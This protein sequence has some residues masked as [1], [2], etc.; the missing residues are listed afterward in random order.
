MSTISIDV[1]DLSAERKRELLATMLEPGRKKPRPFPLSFAQ[2]R[3]W[4]VDQLAPESAS[5]N[6]PGVL[7]LLGQL[8]IDVLDRTFTE[9][10][11]RHASLRTIFTVV[12]DQPMQL[13][14]P[15]EL[16][17]LPLAD[18]SELSILDR[19]TEIEERAHAEARR[20]FDLRQGPLWRGQLL[21]VSS[22]EHVLLFTLHHIIGDGWSLG[23]LFK[24]LC[25]IYEAFS[26]GLP[27]PLAE[28][29]I[30]YVD[31]ALW[32][33]EWL[34]GEVLR[35]HLNYWRE[36]LKGAP[37]VIELPTDRARPAIQQYVGARLPLSFPKN[38][39]MGLKALHRQDGITLFM[40]LLAGWQTLLW[41]YTG[42]SDVVIGAPI[43]NRQ[44]TELEPLIGF[45]VNTLVLRTNLSGEP[46]VRELL[47]RVREAC[48]G[49]YAHQDMPFEALVDEL[50]PE[51]ALSH[52]PLFQVMMVLQD[53]I[54]RS[55]EAAELKLILL[56]IDNSTAKF[57]LML[58]LEING[59]EL[60][61]YLEFNTDLFEVDTI[62]RM[63]G[64]YQTLLAGMLADQDQKI[65][66]LPLMT[67]AEQ[68]QL[69]VQW[70]QTAFTFSPDQPVHALFDLQAERTPDAIAVVGFETKISY[71]SL[72][73]RAN[74]LAQHLQKLG[75]GAEAC[76]AV[77]LERS[78]EWVICLLAILKAGA[79]Y[80]P[81]DASS[82]PERI[83]FML[84]D[85]Q[86][87]IVLTSTLLA[88]N[89]DG[90]GS[91]LICLDCEWDDLAA[92]STE[93]PANRA[94]PDNLA[95][96]IYTSGST[97][98]PKG[99]AVAHRELQ[100]LVQWHSGAFALKPGDRSTQLA[101]L[102]FDATVWELWPY[103]TSGACIYLATEEVRVSPEALRDWL[104]AEEITVSWVPTPLAE[105]LLA[106]EWP[107]NTALR[108]LNI[109]GEQL[110]RYPSASLPFAVVN[111]Y[112]PT[113]AT[114][115]VSS[116][117][118]EPTELPTHLP[119]I[120]RPIANVKFFV[121]GEQ[122]Q[123][124][125]IGVVGELYVGGAALARGY[126]GLAAATADRFVPHPYSQAGG[127]RLYK[128][129]DLVRYLANGNLDY[130]GR[131]DQQVKIRGYRIEL[132][133]I[134]AVLEQ[135]EAVAEAIA[136]VRDEGGQKRL[137]VYVVG[138]GA[139][140]N[141]QELRAYLQQRLP[142]YMVPAAIVFIDRTP[143]TANGKVD[144]KA[145]PEPDWVQIERGW[146]APRTDTEEV[147]AALWMQ[148][149]GIDQ[150][151]MNNNFFELGGH[152]LLA[153][154]VISRLREA[155]HVEL[156]LRDF[157]QRPTISGLAET[158]NTAI[159]TQQGFKAS[160][161]EHRDRAEEPPLSFAQQRLWF[162][163]HLKPNSSLY[164]IPVAARLTGPLNTKA[165]AESL[166]EIVGRHEILR[167]TFVAKS[168]RPVQVIAPTPSP[169]IL[170]IIDL[171]ELAGAQREATV[172]R[173]TRDESS[174]P[175]DL[176]VGP[177][178]RVKLLRLARDEH[179][180]LFTMHHI[181][182]DGW[183]FGLIARELSEF[184]E[185]FS[186]GEISS[187]PD[188]PI[189][190]ADF[191]SWQQEWL[192]GEA[193]EQQLNY[194][195]RQFSGE[196]P[197]LKLPT[198]RPYPIVQTH[199]GN[200][201]LFGLPAE[202]S[203]ALKSLGRRQGVTL[204]MILLGAFQTLLHRYSDQDD[205]I[206]G[207]VIANR[208][209]KETEG[210]IGLFINPLAFRTSFSG[211]RDFRE[212]VAQVRETTLE[213][214]AHQDLPFEKLVEVLQPER[215]LS[216]PP[217]FQVMFV[218]Q[219][220]P[221]AELE[222]SQLTLTPLPV[223][224][225][226]AGFEL[227]L[228]LT[229]TRNGLEGWWEYKTDLFDV[230][231][232]ERMAGHFEVLLEAIAENP[233]R[234]LSALPLLKPSER[235]QLLQQASEEK[236]H[237]RHD[238]LVHQIFEQQVQRRPDAVAIVSRDEKLTYAELN[239]KANVLARRLL[240]LG[241][242]PDD[243]VAVSTDRPIEMLTAI[244]AVLKSSA[245]YLLIE[246]LDLV[247]RRAELIT[248]SGC[249]VI[250]TTETGSHFLEAAL[251]E[252]GA[253]EC[254]GFVLIEEVPAQPADECDLPSKCTSHNLAS[255]SYPATPDEPLQAIMLDQ[256]ALAH[257]LSAKIATLELTASD[258]LAEIV[259]PFSNGAHSLTL[260]L[261]LA[262]GTV[263]LFDNEIVCLARHFNE[264]LARRSISILS[265][266]P[267]VLHTLA[268][269]AMA[270]EPILPDLPVLRG[271]VFTGESLPTKL[272]VRWLQSSSAVQLF[273]SSG[274]NE[275]LGLASHSS[276]HD[277]AVN[278]RAIQIIE[279][280][281]IGLRLHVLDHQQS[282]L[283]IGI[284]GELYI[285]GAGLGRG[286]LNDARGTAEVFVPDPFGAES[287]ARLYKTGELACCLPNGNIEL[288]GRSASQMKIRGCPI[289][290]RDIESV[291][292]QYPSITEAVVVAL[293][294]ASSGY[295]L[296]AY[297]V[298]DDKRISGAEEVQLSLQEQLPDYLVPLVLVRE[299]LPRV[300][301]GGV[302]RRGL[303]EPEENENGLIDDFVVPRTPTEQVVCGI[304]QEV[305]GISRIGIHDKFF[306]IGGDS[307]KVL[308]MFLLL[309]ELY[310]DA[311]TVVD[312]FKHSTIEFVSSHL[313]SVYLHTES[314]PA[315]E[316]FAL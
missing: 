159:E 242:E 59:E 12:D 187:L 221:I 234:L 20:P 132:G 204:F 88:K 106:L 237:L 220:A 209:R 215:D 315:I 170:E 284:S 176:S 26:L 112:G 283:P 33:R 6:I 280:P 133:E 39:T 200:W 92:E 294:D 164:L 308:R 46:S 276:L 218:L 306:E 7:R 273:H 79:A 60:S 180:L 52:T 183:S 233:D 58:A 227:E 77:Y 122:L 102:G 271:L 120:G 96:I 93:A 90:H 48:L 314:T 5:Y 160:S 143:L 22:D 135:H 181:I 256:W 268:A 10:A 99:V 139:T 11:R 16:V 97:G 151:G 186:R 189:Q 146:I 69:L 299:A 272:A 71:A 8:N 62:R 253:R 175:F 144:H 182:S 28:L 153:T 152:S 138:N 53:A 247:E 197:L 51:R 118:I 207:S 288:K 64:H 55:L 305:L 239:R 265:G 84:S 217:L 244:L 100:N 282:P 249:R 78:P 252:M 107:S 203:E 291:L 222:L 29:T 275:W 2:Q 131:A 212:L 166:N 171:S 116:G 24:E 199:K 86:V 74:Q 54:P 148:V 61:G 111:S 34:Q 38:L 19:E 259:S 14:S 264:E 206:A 260:A 297:I 80:L 302:D 141:I 216:R 117:L 279:R 267:P 98:W 248:H 109:A 134:E 101:G 290:P 219:N 91:R 311:L 229:E 50:A 73:A 124:A 119:H 110:H 172:K 35:D 114:V 236:E 261:L 76:V 65:R 232:I 165:F 129:G 179:V 201:H 262:G 174:R 251:L 213:A 274:W 1:A 316:S 238:H 257:V 190:Y 277:I 167:T 231:T 161:I 301:D 68:D 173:M 184:Y 281:A 198:D 75:I 156:P 63:S 4:L 32:Q 309:N 241:V 195:K 85:A 56:D 295:N 223:H 224:K 304:W 15:L 67:P 289:E 169:E 136:T 140:P 214:Y 66:A 154:Q 155:F 296:V 18:L 121:L 226:T 108:I 293:N 285:G 43:A 42:D 205:I 47:L 125:P 147:L 89:L 9:I 243:I 245:A 21:R 115:V 269:E 312:L 126:I 40:T 36:A 149:L 194:W 113:E 210:L 45:F 3:L 82:P 17:H 240:E 307:L 49:A 157:F 142:A 246:P 254:P 188:L 95:Y 225:G 230:V 70:N 310:P 278:P 270:V 127:E 287:G 208:N 191:A 83:L 150:V 202:L 193:L 162:L 25:A 168:G 255:I 23:V 94:Q 145:L 72:K 178:L 250:L 137:A 300:S 57:D 292:L 103:L 158:L 185:A 123:P 258:N 211:D 313:D 44:R 263:H 87:P 41:R 298:F 163:E 104:V 130:V 30:Q 192:Q 228:S 196:L 303:A 128:T 27:S 81:L 105:C 286:Y 13:I 177:L 31:Y 266:I 235:T 37:P